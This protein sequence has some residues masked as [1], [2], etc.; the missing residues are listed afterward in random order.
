MMRLM[1]WNCQVGGF[2]RKAARVA[3][4][5]PDVLVVPECRDV[6]GEMHFDGTSQ[7]TTKQWAGRPEWQR[8]IGVFSYSDV[9]MKPLVQDERAIDGFA[10]FSCRQSD[11]SFQLVAVWT[12]ATQVRATN[13]RQAHEGL[14]RYRDWISAGD[15]VIMGDFNNN[16]TYENGKPWADLMA[17]MESVGMVQG[18]VAKNALILAVREVPVW[19][20]FPNALTDRGR[21]V[22]EKRRPAC[23]GLVSSSALRSRPRSL[24]TAVFRG[25]LATPP[26]GMVSAYHEFFKEDFG[27]ETR[28]TYFHKR[29]ANSPWHVD[30]CF[31]PA[32]WAPL[33]RQVQVGNHLEWSAD[34]DHVPLIVDVDL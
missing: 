6:V 29:Q 9:D 5:R 13:Y 28:P 30:Y 31:V 23:E 17:R 22:R 3:P 16:H 33:I 12:F 11:R 18:G 7:P 26:W 19:V 24:D 32:S 8:G 34:S 1:S 25:I 10:P 14:V 15:T 20:T 27:K 21:D 4:F 2:P